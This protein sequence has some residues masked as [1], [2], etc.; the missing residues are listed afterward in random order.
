MEQTES[1]LGRYATR[2]HSSNR[3]TCSETHNIRPS[4]I[5]SCF[6]R[7]STGCTRTSVNQY[8]SRIF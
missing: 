4:L 5:V 2:I 8:T 6:T 3:I 1:Y 7:G